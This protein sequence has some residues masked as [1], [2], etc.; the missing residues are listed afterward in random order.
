[1]KCQIKSMKGAF[2]SHN[3]FNEY[4][5]ANISLLAQFSLILVHTVFFKQLKRC[6]VGSKVQEH[7]MRGSRAM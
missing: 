7:S 4:N 6:R 5:T 3:L 1:M 2:N